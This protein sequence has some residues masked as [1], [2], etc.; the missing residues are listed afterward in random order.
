MSDPKQA[1]KQGETKRPDSKQE[2]HTEIKPTDVKN[3]EAVFLGA[4]VVDLISYA[5][6]FPVPGE[7]LI[8]NDF[9]MGHGGKGAN[10][11]VM[12]VRM[13][14]A[15]GMIAK[16]GS[17]KIG[18]DYLQYLRDI[19]V[20]TEHV[21]T[22]DT[23][24]NNATANIIVTKKG[25][26]CIVYVHGAAALLLPQDVKDA[27]LMIKN[28]K[29]LVAVFECSRQTLVE[30][31]RIA[32]K[33]EVTTFVNAAPYDAAM[34]DEVYKL[35]DILC[36]N[37]TEASRIT[38]LKVTNKAEYQAAADAL[39]AKGCKTVIIT[40]GDQG[41]C[42][43]TNANHL[44]TFVAAEKVD[45]EDTTGAGDAFNGAFAYHHVRHPDVGLA[46]Y[47]KKACDIASITVQSPGTQLSYPDR[48]D[49]PESLL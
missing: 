28:A 44:L 26:N 8:G 31:L 47:V 24:A 22:A 11:C 16:V 19:K 39:L 46:D 25:Q 1:N 33:H 40:L 10:S 34:T 29:I 27:E 4:C 17:D 12:A 49:I 20:N 5:D 48:A 42:F 37:E 6:R 43:S 18:K 32:R 38:G 45:V 21:R 15:C 2:K 41:A 14:L 30:A 23:K 7:T 9:V 35:T 3:I 13:G 36:V